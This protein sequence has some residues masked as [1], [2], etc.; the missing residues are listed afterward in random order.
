LPPKVDVFNPADDRLLNQI[1][2][3]CGIM[4]QVHRVRPEARQQRRELQGQA[5]DRGI[6][7]L[8]LGVALKIRGKCHPAPSRVL[9]S[10]AL[11]DACAALCHELSE[12]LTATANYLGGLQ[13]LLEIGYR[14]GQPLPEE[15][16]KKASSEVARAG[17]AIHQ[18]RR[19]LATHSKV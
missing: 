4:R 17:E 16:L 7:L 6:V 9:P 3:G 11:P 18:F 12:R 2:R 19:L 15:I 14:R 10:S 13:R 8:A 5:V 1:I